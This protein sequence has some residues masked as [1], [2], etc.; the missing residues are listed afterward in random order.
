MTANNIFGGTVQLVYK[1]LDDN[2]KSD[3]IEFR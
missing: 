3:E 2:S 1:C